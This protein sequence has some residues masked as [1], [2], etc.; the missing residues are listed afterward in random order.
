PLEKD[1]IIEALIKSGDTPFKLEE[2][3][4]IDFEEGFIRVSDLNNLRRE[5]LETITKSITKSYRRKRPLKR[6]L[7][8]NIAVKENPINILYQCVT[9]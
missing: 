8:K 2:V 9:N 6:N 4:F 1:R 7:D 3:D 5:A